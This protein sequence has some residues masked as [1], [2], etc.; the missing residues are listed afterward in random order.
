MLKVKFLPPCLL[1]VLFLLSCGGDEGPAIPDVAHLSSPVTLLRFDREVMALDTADLDASLAD[2]E[3]RYPVFTDLY[4]RRLLPLRRG[5]FSPEEQRLMLKAYLTADIVA[6]IDSAVQSRFPPAALDRQ[7]EQL[8]QALTYYRYYLPDAPRP[9]TLLT[10][11]SQFEIAAALY[12][13]DNLAVGLEFFLGPDYDYQA[14]DPREPIF[15]QYLSR[16]YTPEHLTGKLLRVVIEDRLPAPRG[17]RLIDQLIYEGKK[18]FLLRRT[19]PETEAHVLHEVSSEQMDWLRENEVAIYAHLQKEEHLYVT[20]PFLIRKYTQP[21]PTTQG[22]PA[23][24]PGRAVNYLGM[25]IVEAYVRANPQVTM[26]E[27]LA[28]TD[29]QEILAA[30]RYK[31]R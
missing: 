3:A 21:A 31:P 29:G 16:A 8:E 5:D 28:K 17:G 22:M 13:E 7:R 15:S 4:L 25:R 9:D 27:L 1:V 10:F 18:L 19:L 6:E 26:T 2:L 12:G 30:A 20:D 23:E 14:V 11:F 24:S